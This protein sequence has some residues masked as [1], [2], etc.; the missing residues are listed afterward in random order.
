[1]ELISQPR[2]VSEAS[3]AGSASAANYPHKQT[4]ISTTPYLTSRIL[5]FGPV[6]L[7][8]GLKER[9]LRIQVWF[10]P[11]SN[12]KEKCVLYQL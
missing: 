7:F 10:Q 11:V 4:N 5:R 2:E 12:S 1:M 6:F 9:L 3:S 8:I